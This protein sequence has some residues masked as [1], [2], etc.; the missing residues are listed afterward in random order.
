MSTYS[1]NPQISL[2]PP[3]LFVITISGSYNG[4][5]RNIL[6]YIVTLGS[7]CIFVR[8]CARMYV[9]VCAAVCVYTC[10]F[11]GHGTYVCSEKAAIR[12]N[13]GPNVMAHS[14]RMW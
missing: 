4:S 1:R 2:A 10:V 7:T 6:A 3:P 9:Y 12:H 13:I 5:V 8:V 11:L 14:R